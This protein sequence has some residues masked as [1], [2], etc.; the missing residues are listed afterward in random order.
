MKFKTLFMVIALLIFSI[1]QIRAEETSLSLVDQNLDRDSSKIINFAEE[2]QNTYK[3]SNVRGQVNN[4]CLKDVSSHGQ[5][6]SNKFNE[7][8]LKISQKETLNDN[9]KKFLNNYKS[10]KDIKVNQTMNSNCL[11]VLNGNSKIK[12]HSSNGHFLIA[13][14]KDQSI[15]LPLKIDISNEYTQNQTLKDTIVNNS[16]RL[17]FKIRSLIPSQKLEFKDNAVIGVRG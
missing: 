5:D 16:A 9:D 6:V 11:L 12:L 13:K 7:I 1:Q 10:K 2:F 15:Y 3:V 8:K 4:V 14:A 17:W